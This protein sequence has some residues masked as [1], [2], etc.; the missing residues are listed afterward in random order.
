MCKLLIIG[1]GNPLRG[2]DGLGWHAVSLLRDM[3]AS[4]GINTLVCHQLTPELAES[5][6]SA[7]RVIFIDAAIGRPAGEIKL[8]KLSREML[9][10]SSSSHASDPA[11]LIAYT[12]A[13]YGRAPQTFTLSVTGE[14]YGYGES[15]SRPLQSSLPAILGLTESLLARL[16]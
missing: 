3:L 14:S 13:L 1:I 10:P 7:E 4:E 2:D 15:L 5:I 8:N 11:R 16:P 12:A 9:S 6:A